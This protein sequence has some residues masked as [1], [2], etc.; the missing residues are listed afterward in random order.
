MNTNFQHKELSQGK[1]QKLSLIEQMA[2]IGSEVERAINWK[3]KNDKNY[4]QLA[5][6][7]ALELID[8]TMA[9]K[10]NRRRL[11][12]IARVRESLADYFA[13]SNQYSSSDQ[14]W[15]NYFYAFGFA[16]AIKARR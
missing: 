10:K 9:D 2:N 8:L 7:R 4:S 1:W 3:N 12:E 5:F 16:A 15:K 11:N 13:G 14:G 6:E